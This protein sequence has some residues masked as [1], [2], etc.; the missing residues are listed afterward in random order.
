MNKRFKEDKTVLHPAVAVSSFLIIL[1]FASNLFAQIP[2]NGFCQVHRIEIPQGF[3]GFRYANIDDDD[4]NEIVLITPSQKRFGVIDKN[5][6]GFNVTSKFF[7]F[8]LSE[9]GLFNEIDKLGKFYIFVSEK[10]RKVGLTSFTKKGSMILLN[11]KTLDSYPAD[12]I[13]GDVN[14]EPANE[15][16]I[17]GSNFNGLSLV[18]QNK[19]KVIEEKIIKNKLFSDAAFIDLDYDG[20]ND[21]AAIDLIGNSVVLLMNNNNGK[22]EITRNLQF[23]GNIKN[24]SALDFNKDNFTDLALSS[25]NSV[26]VLFGDSVSSFS[27]KQ[28]IETGTEISNFGF[29]DLNNDKKLDLFFLNDKGDCYLKLSQSGSYG[30][31]FLLAGGINFSGLA[32]SKITSQPAL[33]LISPEGKFYSVSKFRLSD[34]T[35]VKIGGKTEYLYSSDINKDGKAD[36][37]FIDSYDNSLKILT[38]GK[39]GLFDK[40]FAHDLVETHNRIALFN[41]SG[42]SYKF[43]CYF[44]SGRLVEILDHDFTKEKINREAVYTSY[45][46]LKV[47]TRNDSTITVLE[48]S[49][50]SLLVENFNK[51]NNHFINSEV[52][53]ADT[54]V[55]GEILFPAE[56]NVFYFTANTTGT[57]FNKYDLISGKEYFINVNEYINAADSGSFYVSAILDAKK[58]ESFHIIGNEKEFV[59]LLLKGNKK[60]ELKTEGSEFPLFVKSAADIKISENNKNKAYIYLYDHK[61][62]FLYCAEIMKRKRKISF[63]KLFKINNAG[64]YFI[65]SL[66]KDKYVI[67]SDTADNTILF[68]KIND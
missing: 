10:S 1:L 58:D 43:C 53:L 62:D 6:N 29:S 68:R 61:T 8:P 24:L 19:F 38:G 54:N 37:Y 4:E 7:F 23:S 50:D 15:A 5:D 34:S 36:F 20:F 55:S 48:K 35:A 67:S 51:V 52:T 66:G 28:V 3:S 12:F 18:S 47:F 49:G 11:Q 63:N 40:L 30:D 39:T 17:Y 45:P 65:E 2:V 14:Q 41:N 57:S 16:L 13:T 46:I 27:R 44:E 59:Y 22:Y 64:N 25:G 32:L 21:V 31:E 33:D 60:I 56:N 42:M 26:I 9:F